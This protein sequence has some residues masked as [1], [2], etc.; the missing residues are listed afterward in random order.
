MKRICVEGISV[1]PSKVVCVGRNY[2]EHI[3]E[4][5]NEMPS[6]PVLFIKPNSAI[7]EWL[8]LAK[9]YHYEGEIALLIRAGKPYA[10]GFGLDLTDR[11]LQS[12]LKKKGLPWERAKAFDGS[13]LFS[14][15]VPF[16]DDLSSLNLTL[17]I[18]GELRQQGGVAEMIHQPLA[19]IEEIGRFFTLEDNDIVLTGTPKGVGE[20]FLGDELEGALFAGDTRLISHQWRVQP[21][22]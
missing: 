4:L 10:V 17:K 16:S 14:D 12:K 21:A 13:A 18:N 22:D 7:S 8:V 6:E 20:L 5:G 3:T 1:V 2:V 15:F 11:Q 9:P 19:L